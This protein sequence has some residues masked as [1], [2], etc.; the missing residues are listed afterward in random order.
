LKPLALILLSTIV[1]ALGVSGCG[2]K[3]ASSGPP[4]GLIVNATY[5]G[6][7]QTTSTILGRDGGYSG[8]FQGNAVWLYGDTFLASQDAQGQTLISD[9]WSF[10]TNLNAISG[11]QERV[12][13]TGAP[14]M[15]LPLTADEQA[16][17]LAHSGNPCQQQPCGARWAL[18]PGPIVFDPVANRALIFYSL[19]SA[20]PG[21]FNFQGLGNSVAIWQDFTG[22]PQRPVISP[23]IVAGHPDL[24][25]SQN[26]P[27]F[28]SAAFIQG[29]T[30]Y[31]YGC[32][33]KDGADKSCRLGR[34]D[35]A[36]VL[37]R[38]AWTFFAGSDNWSA[39]LSDA[40]PVFTGDDIM[41]VSWNSN[42]Q[43][44]VAIY[45]Q[46]LSQNVMMRTAPNPEGPWSGEITAFV[47]MQPAAGGSNVHDAMAHPE[48]NVDGG[49]VMFVSY[50]R[51]TGAF[52]SEVRLVSLEVK[53]Q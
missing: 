47:A 10:S 48:Y 35:P 9:S 11:F 41:N 53:A 6:T 28:G 46:P 21:A 30:L 25:F 2:S 49:R 14:T 24:L 23:T 31:V 34:V 43:R 1:A 13:S 37:D 17:N 12:D 27:G 32:G 44:Y 39:Q 18:W 19:V 45:S 20:L 7:L 8:I 50:S 42:L 4:P 5:L 22:Q 3:Y 52:S 15:I 36:R 16:F 51:S 29:G 26:E 33:N 40:I 38:S